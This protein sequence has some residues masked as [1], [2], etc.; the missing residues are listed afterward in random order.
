MGLWVLMFLPWESNGLSIS[1]PTITSAE[2]SCVERKSKYCVLS[3]LFTSILKRQS[4]IPLILIKCRARH[5]DNCIPNNKINSFVQETMAL[6]LPN[7]IR[8]NLTF[9]FQQCVPTQIHASII[10]KNTPLHLMGEILSPPLSS[11]SVLYVSKV[12]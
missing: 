4:A 1:Q 8:E 2:G 7:F 10:Y 3:N 11:F 9:Q 5:Y 12:L 6:L